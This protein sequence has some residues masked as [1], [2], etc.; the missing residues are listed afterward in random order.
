MASIMARGASERVSPDPDRKWAQSIHKALG[1]EER[2]AIQ[3]TLLAQSRDFHLLWW[4]VKTTYFSLFSCQ[5]SYP[6]R[7]SS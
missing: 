2:Q 3:T 5:H 1:E 7:L 4:L 6:M